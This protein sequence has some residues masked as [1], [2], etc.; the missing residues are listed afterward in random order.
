[1]SR[2]KPATESSGGYTMV[3]NSVL[4]RADLSREARLL[5]CILKSYAWQ[6]ESCWPSQKTLAED[7]DFE[8]R[9]SIWRYTKEL[10]KAGLVEA[11]RQG[12]GQDGLA[13]LVERKNTPGK[14]RP[15]SESLDDVLVLSRN[16]ATIPLQD[17]T[18]AQTRGTL[19]VA[20]EDDSLHRADAFAP[21]GNGFDSIVRD[22]HAYC[23]RLIDRIYD[24]PPALKQRMRAGDFTGV[25]PFLAN[26]PGYDLMYTAAATAGSRQLAHILARPYF[27]P[28]V[29]RSTIRLADCL[30]VT[31]PAL[32]TLYAPLNAAVHVLH[33]RTDA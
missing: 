10:V 32:A 9:A 7:M 13:R 6:D 16:F 2:P 4:R 3:E 11:V 14:P 26:H 24:L 18:T 20:D 33:V 17:I 23:E 1:M 25:F 12:R 31:T 29:N 22:D 30:T 21:T 5:Y 8:D 15:A 27:P 28:N 19:V